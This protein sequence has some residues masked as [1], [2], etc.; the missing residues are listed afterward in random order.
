MKRTAAL[1]LFTLSA[2][3]TYTLADNWPGGMTNI[4]GTSF[5]VIYRD[6][7]G[8]SIAQLPSD[9]TAEISSTCGTDKPL[10]L[11]GSSKPGKCLGVM[12][13]RL[14]D[15]GI[16][17]LQVTLPSNDS[18]EIMLLSTRNINK[19]KPSLRNLHDDELALL[20]SKFPNLP[21]KEFINKIKEADFRSSDKL[22]FVP[23]EKIDDPFDDP[24]A[25]MHKIKNFNLN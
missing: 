25:P 3:P 7:N 11:Y 15:T 14:A 19:E 21:R 4:P 23:V 2:I 22:F 16:T 6:D 1:L 18:K 12:P 10:W 5:A 8:R 24:S 17:E 13:V 20:I 9:K